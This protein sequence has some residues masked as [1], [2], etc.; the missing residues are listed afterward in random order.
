MLA[1]GGSAIHCTIEFHPHRGLSQGIIPQ[2][3]DTRGALPRRQTL[4]HFH[5]FHYIYFHHRKLRFFTSAAD[6]TLS[7]EML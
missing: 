6:S 3:G 7:Q 2:V 5:I 4:T 1:L